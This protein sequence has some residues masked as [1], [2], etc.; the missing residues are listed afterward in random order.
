MHIL[1]VAFDLKLTFETHTCEVVSKAARSLGIVHWA[2]KC[3]PHV[4]YGCFNAYV[5]FNLVYCVPVWMSSVESHLSLLDSV[6]CSAKRLCR[7]NF[8][9]CTTEGR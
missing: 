3:C 8:V 1:G 2:E 9:V 4:L 5:L 6:V 7:F